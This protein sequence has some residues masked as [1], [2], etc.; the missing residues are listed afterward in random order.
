MGVKTSTSFKPGQS[1]NPKGAPKKDWTWASVLKEA[2]EEEAKTGRP[3]K[4]LMAKSMVREV[5]KGNVN[6]FNA[7]VNRM[8]GMPSQKTDITSDGEA[9]GVVI[10]RPK[11]PDE[12]D[13]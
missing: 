12:I 2:V 11:R 3:V 9:I 7:V 10:Y 8:D 1:G 13:E 6:A 5:M 4:E